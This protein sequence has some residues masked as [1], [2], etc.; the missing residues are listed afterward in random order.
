MND[1]DF[2]VGTWDSV[3]RRLT[4]VL[5]GCDEWDEFS[6]TTECIS[7]LGGAANLD[8][9]SF[10][11]KGFKGVTL[12]LFDPESEEW[13]LYWISS[14][15]P[16]ID[17]PQVGRFSDGVGLFFGDDTFEGRPIRV[18]FRWF[19]ITPT[20]ARWDQAFSVD[21]EKSWETNWTAEFT[22]RS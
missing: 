7:L 6:G 3:Q 10:P 16:A 20:T 2:F 15:K 9:V 12:R 13:S 4:K 14:R 21:G 11:T 17:D 1:F 19:D 18:R 22:R 5:A 8:E